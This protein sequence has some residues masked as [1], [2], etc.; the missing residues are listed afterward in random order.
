MAESRAASG[1]SALNVSNPRALKHGRNSASS[2]V[3]DPGSLS[4][5]RTTHVS[6]P[7]QVPTR[8]QGVAELETLILRLGID[9]RTH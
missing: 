9:R 6:T 1:P 4:D 2:R 8:R 3:S 7:Q 5:R